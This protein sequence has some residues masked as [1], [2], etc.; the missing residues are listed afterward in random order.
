[1]KTKRI[2][3]AVLFA[4]ILT[5]AFSQN[6]TKPAKDSIKEKVPYQKF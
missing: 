5:Q 1:M 4:L 3:T 2:T 6:H